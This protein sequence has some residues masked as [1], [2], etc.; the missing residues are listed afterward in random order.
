MDN[1]IEKDVAIIGLACRLP[2]SNNPECLWNNLRDGLDLVTEFKKEGIDDDN[3]I[4]RSAVLDAIDEFDFEFFNMTKTE[5]E[6]MD[7]QQR[8]FLECCWEVL[9]NAGYDPTYYNGLIGITA[10][11]G[12][13]QYLLE[14]L[15]NNSFV[16]T[17]GLNNILLLNEKDF[18]CTRAAYKLNLKGAS[19][20]IQ[21]ACSSSLVAI[22]HACESL[23]SGACDMMIAGG[24]SLAVPHHQGYFYED[25]MMMSAN[26]LCQPFDANA[27]GTIIGNGCSIVLLKMLVDAVEDGDQIHA[28]IK[29]SAVNNDGNQKATFSS[30]SIDGQ[31]EAI[32]EALEAAEVH[33]EDIGF[34]E[35]HGTGTKLGDPIEIEAL[36][37]AYNAYT[38]KKQYCAIG[39]IK[40]NL[41]H[42]NTAAGVTGLIKAVLSLKNKQIPPSLHYSSPNPHI[43]FINSPFYVNTVLKDW[44]CDIDKKRMAAVSSFGIGGTNAHMI[45]EEAPTQPS[46]AVESHDYYIIPLSAC[47]QAALNNIR[48]RLLEYVISNPDINLTQLAFTLQTGRK[49]FRH[50]S[51][52]LCRDVQDLIEKLN[53]KDETSSTTL[54]IEEAYAV[55]EILQN[56]RE[57]I[58][59][60]NYDLLNQLF[61]QYIAPDVETHDK[62]YQF[63]SSLSE[64]WLLGLDINWKYIY[65]KPSSIRK[66]TLP[67]YP[68]ERKRCWISENT[69]EDELVNLSHSL[70]D[71]LIILWK[72]YLGVQTLSPDD[73][74]FELGGD[75]LMA[76]NLVATINE[77]LNL[78]LK[79]DSLLTS[80]TINKILQLYAD[81]D[82]SKKQVLP[83][84]IVPMKISKK[85]AS[86]LFL[87]HPM[88]GT[89]YFYRELVESL[90][91]NISVYAIQ[92]QSLD[93][94]SSPKAN[95]K[96]LASSYIVHIK[97]I[98]PQGPYRLGGSSF[99]GLIAYEIAQQLTKNGEAIELLALIDSP[100]PKF[101]AGKSKNIEE[102]ILYFLQSIAGK[103]NFIPAIKNLDRYIEIYKENSRALRQYKP[104]PYN[105]EVL[106]FSATESSRFLSAH[107][108]SGWK[109]L[110]KNLQVTKVSGDHISMNIKPN[111]KT[112]ADILSKSLTE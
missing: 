92:A 23:R 78:D 7:P 18:L 76:V 104:K 15:D 44:Y 62:A 71:N 93:G 88:G 72:R 70:C 32:I 8:L 81:P 19:A 74:F 68:F 84:C 67:T 86:P 57:A 43:D 6:A 53:E 60:K 5:A 12:F 79:V 69:S 90:D 52:I 99:G 94:A 14:I 106:F 58:L 39:S 45:L 56:N 73:N 63:F 83:F 65:S 38:N 59:N 41:G 28:V 36:S 29:G 96:T 97:K 17:V 55:N 16:K 3:Y 80:P 100:V 24:V 105:G 49:A 42:T 46:I 2:K 9:E 102:E 103:E 101:I 85:T 4:P 40:S 89:T 50:R 111:V 22:H 54:N 30:P 108:E 82:K 48:Q 1:S 61:S 11:V 21:T 66:L 112:I 33:P 47:S 27:S 109:D 26:G 91:N 64:I 20:T 87:V 95:I 25:G 13:S 110:V 107:L 37:Q 31:R 98:Q 34:I 10:G 51:V 77:E 35:A 75:S